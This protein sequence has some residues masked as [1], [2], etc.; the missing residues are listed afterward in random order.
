M[1]LSEFEGVCEFLCAFWCIWVCFVCLSEFVCVWVYLCVWCVLSVLS[2]FLCVFW[3]CW[4]VYVCVWWVYKCVSVC[5]SVFGENIKILYESRLEETIRTNSIIES[6][7][8]RQVW[9]ILAQEKRVG[10]LSHRNNKLQEELTKYKVVTN[11]NYTFEFSEKNT[12][13][14]ISQ[15]LMRRIMINE[16]K[17]VFRSIRSVVDPICILPQLRIWRDS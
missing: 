9:N 11:K 5:F 10:Y 4:C 12:N 6:D 1:C 7:T 3:V 13:K 14:N 17:Q 16:E 8:I 2:V 15:K